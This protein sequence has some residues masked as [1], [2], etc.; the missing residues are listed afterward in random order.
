MTRED[1]R[2]EDIKFAIDDSN[3]LRLDRHPEYPASETM[4][5]R[6]PPSQSQASGSHKKCKVGGIITPTSLE[7]K[8][9]LDPNTETGNPNESRHEVSSSTAGSKKRPARRRS[10]STKAKA[11]ARTTQTDRTKPPQAQR[12]R[13]LRHRNASQC[14]CYLAGMSGKHSPQVNRT[15]EDEAIHLGIRHGVKNGLGALM[16]RP[17]DRIHH[18]HHRNMTTGHLRHGGITAT[19]RRSEPHRVNAGH[20][21]GTRWAILGACE[22]ARLSRQICLYTY[23]SRF[24]AQSVTVS[25]RMRA[26]K[27]L[28][29]HRHSLVT[30]HLLM[31]HYIYSIACVT[32]TMRVQ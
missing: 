4:A 23:L 25:V 15:E 9:F 5:K 7:R 28:F 26:A 12:G 1:E 2:D 8:P 31:I 29:C 3:S 19:M 22:H 16:P 21:P 6:G 30:V 32:P 27:G 13:G 24:A 20:A 11:G 14:P 10:G 17:K 18:A